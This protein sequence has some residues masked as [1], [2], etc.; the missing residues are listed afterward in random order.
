MFTGIIEDVGQV[1]QVMPVAEVRRLEIGA[2]FAGE[3]AVGESVAV[4]GVCLTVTQQSGDRF[5]VDVVQETLERTTLAHARSGSHVNLERA[6]RVGDR[7]SGHFVQGHVDGVGQILRLDRLG[8]GYWLEVALPDGAGAYVVEKGSIAIDGI[9]LTVARK[10]GSSIGV[11]IIPHTFENTSLRYKRVG[12]G[13]NIE[14][15]ILGKYV[16]SILKETQGESRLTE[17][18]LR[19]QGFY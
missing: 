1:L 3:L 17:D 7:L 13:V 6:L 2:R 12:D 11:A 10:E 18:W 5:S 16:A 4:D 8:E 14:L 15:D 9:S 19:E